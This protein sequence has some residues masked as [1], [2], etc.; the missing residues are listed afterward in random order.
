LDRLDLEHHRQQQ[1]RRVLLVNHHQQVHTSAATALPPATTVAN[2]VTMSTETRGRAAI[3]VDGVVGRH[4]GRELHPLRSP[5]QL[6]PKPVPLPVGLS[7]HELELEVAARSPTPAQRQS[8]HG[9]GMLSSDHSDSD[10]DASRGLTV[11][12][13]VASAERESAWARAEVE[14]AAVAE[15]CRL[16]AVAERSSR[17][18]RSATTTGNASTLTPG[19]ISPVLQQP[20]Y[21]AVTNSVHAGLDAADAAV[22]R[23]RLVASQVEMSRV[24][25]AHRHIRPGAG[26]DSSPPPLSTRRS[27]RL[28][29]QRSVHSGTSS[30]T[31]E[32]LARLAEQQSLMVVQQQQEHG[33]EAS[34]CW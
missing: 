32:V 19:S 20:H 9:I 30:A 14:A 4:R 24:S 10:D 31:T 33:R 8:Y 26:G 18:E 15:V 22:A 23:A 25:G 16:H 21:G 34:G 7:L 3:T 13:L 27:P 11:G 6:L 5:S 17:I 28:P 2:G 29:Q 1:Q 12:N